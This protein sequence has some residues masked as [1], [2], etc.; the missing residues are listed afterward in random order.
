MERTPCSML[1]NLH[2]QPG[3]VIWQRPQIIRTN[4]VVETVTSE[5][6]LKFRDRDFVIKDET[7]KFETATETRDLTFL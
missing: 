5:T 2:P 3:F 1:A 6:W 4:G 7:W